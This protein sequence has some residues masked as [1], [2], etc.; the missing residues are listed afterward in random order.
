MNVLILFPV[1]SASVLASSTDLF[2]A[3]C[4]LFVFGGPCCLLP[5]KETQGGGGRGIYDMLCRMEESRSLKALSAIYFVSDETVKNQ[6]LHEIGAAVARYMSR[7]WIPVWR[8]RARI[9]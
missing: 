6:R 3:V 9:E 8:Y 7:G 5:A 1:A 2:Q 4:V